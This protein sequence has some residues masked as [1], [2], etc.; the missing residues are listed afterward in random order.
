M[1]LS[2]KYKFILS[3]V[4]L[5]IVFILLIVLYN[6]STSKK[7]YDSLINTN[8]NT[9]SKLFAEVIKTPLIINDLATI[10]NYVESLREMDY[11]VAIRIINFENIVISH[12]NDENNYKIIFDNDIPNVKTDNEILQ[13]K[14]FPIKIEGAIL[15]KVQILYELSDIQN[16]IE[17]NKNKTFLLILL[18]I[19]CSTFIAYYIGYKLTKRLSELTISAE[20][21]SKD[22]QISIVKEKKII[23]EISILANTL[24]NMQEKI[25]KRNLQLKESSQKLKKEID[26][27]TALFNNTNSA[28]IVLNKKYEIFNVN[29]K[30]E[31][32]TGHIKKELKGKHVWEILKNKNIKTLIS[33]KT[34]RNYPKEYENALISKDGTNPLYTWTNSFTYNDEGKVE[35]II[36]VGVDISG[37]KEIQHRL[38]KYINLVNENIIISRT[39]LDGIITDVSEAFCKISG[40]SKDELIGQSHVVIRHKDTPI[41]VY[42]DLWKT[43]KQGK[44]WQS[45]VKNRTKD[46]NFYW[47]DSTIYPDYDNK[48]NIVGYYAIRHDI[49]NKKF[50]E[51]LSITDPLTKLYNRRYFD[52]IFDKEFNRAKRE[53]S[54]FCLLSMDIDCFKLYNDTYGHLEGDVVLQSISKVLQMNLKRTS[55]FVFRMGGEEFSAIF[56]TSSEENIYEF[57]ENIRSSIENLQIKH[58]NNLASPF[59][60]SSIGVVFINFE[61]NSQINIS[62]S[63][64]Y[65]YSDD[66]LYKAK[67]EGRNRVCIKE[68]E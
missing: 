3:F 50:I 52:D 26:F 43:I 17:E 65:K 25:F 53:E 31:I 15:G 57:A 22:K 39:N 40:F 59:V 37:I 55:D 38:Q 11:I 10:D 49:T 64:L 24:S 14:S 47:A 28:I 7:L 1:K 46:G 5:E 8:I 33:G 19:F 20:E 35:Y 12:F 34:V 6:F 41:E 68:V 60:T 13:L 54:I 44:I 2:F 63:F 42:E 29:E 32:L 30:V 58:E 27:H 21:I 67:I 4:L 18:E 16:I 45:E 9:S 62:Q 56:V 48:G 61:K 66:L 51:N 36:S 23:D